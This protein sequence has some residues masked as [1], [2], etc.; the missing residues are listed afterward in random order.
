M[1][2]IIAGLYPDMPAFDRRG[3]NEAGYP[4]GADYARINPKYFDMA[5]LRIQ[6]LVNRGLVP[7][8]VGCWGYFL[9]F[10]GLPKI[11]QHWRN[12]VARWGAYPVMWC[13]A[14][15]GTMPYYLSQNKSA[16]SAAQ[17]TVGPRWRAMSEILI[18]TGT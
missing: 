5:D 17:K 18:P 15:E 4:W 1:I 10:M 16:D 6:E 2:Q 12:I 9:G 8:I 3:A 7:C 13:L 11:K 14:G